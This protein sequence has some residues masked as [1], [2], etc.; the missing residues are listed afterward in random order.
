MDIR[1]DWLLPLKLPV[2]K[3]R[4]RPAISEALQARIQELKHLPKTRIAKALGID[5]NTV[6]RYL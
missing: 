6:A 2:L 5:R 4:G 1:G 3:K